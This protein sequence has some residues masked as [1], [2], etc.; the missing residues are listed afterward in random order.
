[1]VVDTYGIDNNFSYPGPIKSTIWFYR[2][3]IVIWFKNYS[4]IL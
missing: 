1:M 3:R 4:V 2:N